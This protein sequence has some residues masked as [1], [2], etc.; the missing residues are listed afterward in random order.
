MTYLERKIERQQSEIKILSEQLGKEIECKEHL[1]MLVTEE[2][3]KNCKLSGHLS[4]ANK[5][6]GEMKKKIGKMETVECK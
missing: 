5:L 6:N 2:K 3:E 4:N 1:M